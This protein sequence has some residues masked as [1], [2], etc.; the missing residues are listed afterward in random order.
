MSLKQ[1]GE[2][3]KSILNNVKIS[4]IGMAIIILLLILFCVIK[5]ILSK[6]K[7]GKRTI[8][9]NVKEF[10]RDLTNLKVW[11]RIILCI[12]VVILCVL[13]FVFCYLV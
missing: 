4:W 9:E 10:C 11:K 2:L 3:I 5:W 8:K 12:V 6:Y 7:K 13:V 1:T